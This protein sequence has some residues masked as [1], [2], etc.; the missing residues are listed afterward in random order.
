MASSLTTNDATWVTPATR[1]SG[2][3]LTASMWNQQVRDNENVLKTPTSSYGVADQASDY[4]TTSATY[5]DVDATYMTS[6]SRTWNGGLVNVT[7]QGTIQSSLNTTTIAFDIAV[8]GTRVAGDDGLIV[9]RMTTSNAG[10]AISFSTW[11]PVAAGSHT[12]SLQWKTS[13]GTATLNAGAGTSSYD[14]HPRFC[15]VEA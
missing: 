14:I 3:A 2:D 10:F 7:F 8:D 6:G 9:W 11:I 4:T 13:G 15:C 12:I 5:A 1:A